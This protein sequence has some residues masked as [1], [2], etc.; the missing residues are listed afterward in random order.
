MP[1]KKQFFLKRW[2]RGIYSKFFTGDVPEDVAASSA[3]PLWY[4]LLTGLVCGFGAGLANLIT[5]G[6]AEES[7]M[8][9]LAVACLVL[10]AAFVAYNL[11]KTQKYI[12]LKGRKVLRAV[13][14]LLTGFVFAV[15]G[16]FVG[17][18]LVIAVI[19][20]VVGWIALKLAFGGRDGRKVITLDD[21]TKVRVMRGP[22][23]E[24]ILS[25]ND[26]ATYQRNSDGTF[27][28]V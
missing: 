15:L 9:G 2:M 27:S 19:V 14:M 8:A 25:G 7:W 28:K 23:G 13:M 11:V 4:S 22:T 20:V 1:Q 24:E 10:S 3:S 26:G 12:E 5:K 21:G 6:D 17:F 16:F 18:W